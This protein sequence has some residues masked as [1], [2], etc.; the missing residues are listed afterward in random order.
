[1]LC[2]TRGIF[3]SPI[4]G[5]ELELSPPF[6][7]YSASLLSPCSM[8]TSSCSSPGNRTPVCCF[9]AGAPVPAS[10]CQEV[11]TSHGDVIPNVKPQSQFPAFRCQ[12]RP[13]HLPACPTVYETPNVGCSRALL[14]KDL[15]KQPVGHT[16]NFLLL[17]IQSNL[18]DGRQ[19]RKIWFSFPCIFRKQGEEAVQG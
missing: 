9:T 15:Q 12:I 8:P 10:G 11:P 1:M 16:P 2:F 7:S 6:A 5:L 19:L 4:L 13:L 3:R 14:T 18:W 17:G